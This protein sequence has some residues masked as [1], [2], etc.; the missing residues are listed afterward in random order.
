MIWIERY[1]GTPFTREQVDQLGILLGL[2]D[3]DLSLIA[4]LH[5]SGIISAFISIE[6]R[7]IAVKDVKSAKRRLD[8]IANL[9]GQLAQLLKAEPI[10]DGLLPGAGD[11]ESRRSQDDGIYMS[12]LLQEDRDRFRAFVDTLQ[13]IRS[14]AN[15]TLRDDK[16]FRLAHMLPQADQAGQS[17]FARTLWPLLLDYWCHAGKRPAL[18]VNGPLHR[19]IAIIHS[20]IEA[21]EPRGSTLKDA[22][23]QWRQDD[24]RAWAATDPPW[25][26][27]DED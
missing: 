2:P 21:P 10:A 23:L 16:R 18:T 3:H 15:W 4:A 20:A 5:I 1:E 13:A 7:R 8:R 25:R 24:R 17:P 9:A 19:F 6:Q 11:F 12:Q 22:V 27:E 26:P 14:N